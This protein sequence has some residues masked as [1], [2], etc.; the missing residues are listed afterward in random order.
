MDVTTAST[1]TASLDAETGFLLMDGT[2]NVTATASSA[3]LRAQGNITVG[4]ITATNVSI[5]SDTA[6]IINAAGSTKNVTATNLRLQA[7]GSIGTASRHLTTNIDIVSALASTGSIYV[8]EDNTATVDTVSV[9]VTDFNSDATTTTVTDAAQSDLTTGLN[10]NIV[11]VATLGDITLNDGTANNP[12][13]AVTANGTGNILIDSIAGSLTANADIL[14]GTGHITLKGRVNL[15]LTAAVDVTTASTG[16]ASLDAETGFLLMDGTANV[17][18]T[19]SSARL[20]AQGNITVGNVTATHV[21]IDSDTA[22]IINAAGSTKNVTATNLRLQAQGSIGTATRHLTTNIDIVSALASTGSIYVTEDNGATVQN[23]TVT[24]TD[25]NSDATTTTVTD[26]AQSDLTT[27][28]NGNIVLVATLGDITLNDGTANNPGTAVTAHGTGNILIDSV[29]GSL[30]ANAD[31][32]SGTGHITLSA[33][34]TISLTAAVDVTTGGTGT[35]DIRATTQSLLMATTASL[36]TVNGDVRITVGNDASDQVVLGDITA[37]AANVSIETSGSVLDADAAGDTDIDIT[38]LGLRIDAGKGIGLLSGNSLSAATNAIETTI[39]TLSAIARGSDGIHIVETNALAI[40]DVI[41]PTDAT[42]SVAVDTVNTDATVTRNTEV[43]QSDLVTTA[44]NGANGSIVLRTL[45]G[46]ITFSEGTATADL[47]IDAS[48]VA[49]GSGNVLIQA[50]GAGTDIIALTTADL[51]STSGHI[52]LKAA[53]NITLG[54]SV[55]VST[56]SA[57]TLSLDAQTGALTMDGTANAVSTGSSARLRAQGDI[58]VG[59]ITATHVSIDSDTAAIINA[60]G[61][62]KNVTATNLRLQAQTSIGTASRHLTTNLDNVTALAATGS[63]YVTEDNGAT[64]QNVTVTVQDVVAD[65]TVIAVTDAAQSDLTT[66]LNGNIVLVAKLGD[67]TLND[68]TAPAGGNAVLAHGTGSVRIEALAGSIT[69]NADIRST[70]GHL[71]FR[72]AQNIS[73]NTNVDLVT[74][75]PGTVSL[76]A[77]AGAL[78]MHGSATAVATGSSLRLRAQGDITVGNLTATNVSLDSDAASIFNAL[79]SSKNVTATNLR[80]QAKGQVAAYHRHLTTTVDTLTAVVENGAIFVTEDN[81]VTVGDVA[82]TITN[83]NGDATTTAVTDA[84]QSDLR[85]SAANGDIVLAAT[86]GNITLNDGTAPADGN[87]IVTTTAG[88]VTLFANAGSIIANADIRSATGYLTL[89]AAQNISLNTGVDL[90]TASLG[91]ASLNAVAGTLTMHGTATVVATGS[92]LRLRAQGDIT[93]GNLTATNVSLDSDAGSIVNAAL[94]TKNVTATTLRLQAQNSIGAP[95][96]HLTTNIDTVSALASTGSIYVTEDNAAIVGNVAVTVTNIN[97]DPTFLAVTDAAQADFTTGQN[98]DIVLVATLGDLTLNDGT[99]PAGGNAILAHGSGSVRLDAVAGSIIANADIRSSFGHLTLRAGQN[100]SLNTGVEV[101]TAAL[102]TASLNAVAGALTMHGTA[103]VVAT[104]SSAR[105]RAQGDVTVGNITA[106]NVSLDSDAGSLVNAAGSTKNVTATRLRLQAQNAIGTS[107]RHL[108]TSVDL[109]SA[110]AATGSI[111]VTE[112]NG[113]TVDDVTVTVLDL[114]A[115]SIP[116]AVVDAVQSDVT[117]GLNGNIVLV[118]TTGNLTVNDATAPADGNAIV[119][120]GSGSVRLEAVTGMIAA[121]ADIRSTTGHLALL[122]GSGITLAAAVDVAAAAP[123]TVSLNAGT[124]TLTMDGT[125]KVLAT[126]SSARLRAQ[127]NVTVGT[128]TATDVSIDSDAGNIYRAALSGQNV[129]ATNLRLQAQQSAGRPNDHLALEVGTLTGLA[130]TGGLF[131]TEKDGLTVSNVAVS[132]TQLNADAT[133][134]L[135]TDAAQSDLV[136]GVF[137][138]LVLVSTAGDIVLEDGSDADGNA[139]TAGGAGNVLL[140]APAGNITVRTGADLVATTGNVTLKA[141]LAMTFAAGADV[142]TGGS[143]HLYAQA[144]GGSLTQNDDG[145][146]TTASGNVQLWGRDDVVLGGVTTSATASLIAGTG[147]VIDAGDATGGAD[148]IASALRVS[149]AVAFGSVAAPLESTVATLAARSGSGGFHLRESDAVTLGAVDVGVNQVASDGEL[150]FAFF[151]LGTTGVQTTGGNG[152]VDIRTTAGAITVSNDSSAHGTGS[153]NLVAGGVSGDIV[154]GAVLSSTTGAV[155]L[156]AAGRIRETTTTETPVLVTGGVLTLTAVSGIGETGRGDLDVSAPSLSFTNS[157]V[158]QAYLK[159]HRAGATLTAATLGDTGSLVFTQVTGG[160]TIS[161]PVNIDSGSATFR[162]AGSLSLSGAPITAEGDISIRALSITT[163]TSDLTTG[164]SGTITL[165][166][167]TDIT[168]DPATSVSAANVTIAAGGNIALAQVDATGLLDITAGGSVTTVDATTS[169][170]GAQFRL[171]TGGDAGTATTPLRVASA[172]ADVSVG[173][174]L[175]IVYLNGL[176]VGR[177]G[178]QFDT[179]TGQEQIITVEGT[180]IGTI[181]GT[182]VDNGT[183]TLHFKSTND[184]TLVAPVVS[185]GGNITIDARSLTD[186]TADENALLTAG[187]GLITLTTTTGTGVAGAG[188]IDLSAAQLTATT[189]TGNLQFDSLGSITVVAPGLQIGSL[190]ALGNIGLNVRTGNLTASSS[191]TN[192]GSGGITLLVPNGAFTMTNVSPISTN[193]G[194]ITINTLGL[195][196]IGRL[197]STTGLISLTTLDSITTVQQ[198]NY[199]NITSLTRPVVSLVQSINILIDSNSVLAIA[200]N[201]PDGVEIVRG[202]SDDID[203]SIYSSI[204]TGND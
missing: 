171:S 19:A 24:V 136:S 191:I 194:A 103:T 100:I 7:Q 99:A 128:L 192:A 152:P 177:G 78:T 166:A 142:T 6:S 188:D 167:T 76:D 101:V 159:S 132:V 27:G 140:H 33:F 68:G 138:H 64:V 110:R 62:T 37:S 12:G 151:A 66:G 176:N 129:V 11:L 81:G 195:M 130:A 57:G 98:G 200:P 41:S 45:G 175:N 122:A 116:V 18:A 147:S 190:A 31:I 158:G 123:G 56:A 133:T 69:A 54:A 88:N 85:S 139:L 134:T 202:G 83:F 153:V 174:L 163:A 87:A 189:Q 183:G 137:G 25:F 117:T 198:L 182:I 63:I 162:V 30:T 23:V 86:L 114:G 146:F 185:V 105:L 197:Q 48:V 46:T 94:S 92:S 201:F 50:I 65:A 75:T 164:T 104:G 2:A 4:N 61:S 40:N 93:V 120:H 72:A 29:A 16:T 150:G 119:A 204:L 109:L 196:T 26:A 74:G 126:G 91:T 143:G 193:V 42:K 154:L 44:T 173:G 14:S 34:R 80:L 70:T 90:V 186:G 127:G 106:D 9:T 49:H 156:T 187:S 157:G 203:M 36:N 71:T 60:A 170:A 5:D 135:V 82:V 141:G 168:L 121:N 113:L 53:R 145:R 118:V 181:G 131:L 73:L 184:I 124:G 180:T 125:A 3:R 10:G 21:S 17:T 35:Q 13:T 77:V 52:T 111:Y 107:A 112:D 39:D 102:G 108:T 51:Q 96:R 28:L 32:L 59:N 22:S 179:D 79:G 8:T 169:L 58:T 148:I 165:V 95:T 161:G 178:M 15:T 172:A 38:A 89:R 149:A 55:D 97:P 144:I 160:L 1:G 155:S 115:D 47:D 84:T 43:T 20:R 199:A 67:L